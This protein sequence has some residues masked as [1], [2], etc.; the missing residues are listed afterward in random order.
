MM[1]FGLVSRIEGSF[2][3]NWIPAFAGM[4]IFL[5][6]SL[7]EQHWVEGY[8][9]L[10]INLKLNIRSGSKGDMVECAPFELS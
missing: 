4:T 9:S 8:F 1:P 3:L 5:E 10:R 7:S 2:S 6:M